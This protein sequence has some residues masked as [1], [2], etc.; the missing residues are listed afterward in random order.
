MK[1]YDVN[2]KLTLATGCA[3]KKMPVKR[4]TTDIFP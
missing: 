1:K 3:A 4:E 2:K